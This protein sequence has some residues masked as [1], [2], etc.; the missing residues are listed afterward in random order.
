MNNLKELNADERDQLSEN[1]IGTDDSV[2]DR[3]RRV[4]DKPEVDSVDSVICACGF[5]FSCGDF[6]RTQGIARASGAADSER[7]RFAENSVH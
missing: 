1:G 7:R 2:E 4:S 6:M 5:S 3:R